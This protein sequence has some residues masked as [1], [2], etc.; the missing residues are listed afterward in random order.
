MK[1][2]EYQNKLL[3]GNIQAALKEIDK[4]KFLK[5]KR[6]KLLYY[7]EKGKV[8]YLNNDYEQSN[9]LLNKADIF[10]EDQ[11][12]SVGNQLLGV[13][14]NPEKEVYNGEDFEKV[15]IHYYK[16]LNYI[17]LNQSDEALVEARKINLQLQKLNDSYPEGKKNRYNTD[18]FALTF[19]GLLYEYNGD[20]NNAF[21]S[22]RNAVDIYLEHEDLY[23]G[24]NCPNQLKIDLLRTAKA[25]GFSNEFLRYKEIFSDI[26]TDF[27]YSSG[28]ELI[29]FWE[30]GLVPYKDQTYYSFSILPG[31][32]DGLLMIQNEEFD[33]FLPIP[34]DSYDEDK[35]SFSDIDIFNIAFPR[36]VERT[37]YYSTAIAKLDS[38]LYQFELTEDYTTIAFQTLKDRTAREIGKAA[39]RLAVKKVS[40]HIIK[41]ENEGL[42]TALGI[43]NAAIEHADTRNWQTLPNNIHYVRIPLKEGI[44][45]IEVEF[46]DK[47][48][49]S[50][51][52]NIKIDGNGSLQFERVIT[53][54]SANPYY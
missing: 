28:G 11:R 41:K 4:N 30:N 15:A 24:T 49:N 51:V 52:E 21:I 6:N 19:Q 2:F 1:S 36:Y 26:D 38:G 32:D 42:G 27:T 22:Y 5:K 45:E 50:I 47:D 31:G 16:A 34:I 8:E 25:I 7:F 43:L 13:I 14:T 35:G 33:I 10:L 53:L 39:I 17:F 54:D 23:F 18:A 46:F 3:S 29:V 20:I 12:A 48:N 44:N 9:L 40:E 37:P